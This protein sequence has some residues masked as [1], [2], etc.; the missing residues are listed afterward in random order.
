[1]VPQSF[2][3]SLSVRAHQADVRIA[4]HA[5]LIVYDAV[6]EGICA[7]VDEA[8]TA[9]WYADPTGRFQY[10]YWDGAT[11]TDQTSSDGEVTT[12]PLFAPP[13]STSA[14][15]AAD[16]PFTW[17]A[18]PLDGYGQRATRIE[19]LERILDALDDVV[20]RLEALEQTVANRAALDLITELAKVR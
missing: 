2:S 20:A 18:T 4:Q 9:G 10:R 15:L 14:T 1:M 17:R 19:H 13:V 16:S 12:D 11:W 8:R 7:V 6:Q 5:P 3:A